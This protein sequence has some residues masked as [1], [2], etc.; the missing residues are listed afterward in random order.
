MDLS[1]IIVTHD[2]E[3]YALDCLRCA[4][5]AA[6]GLQYEIFVIDNAS[7]DQTKVIA[8]QFSKSLTLIENA[9]NQGFAKGI[10]R[11]LKR[12]SG[13]FLLVMNPDIRIQSNSLEPIIDFMRSHPW[14]GICGCR[15]VNKDDSLQPSKGSFPT[16]PS[17]LLRWILPRRLRKYHLWGYEKTGRCDWVTGAFMLMRSSMIQEVGVFDENYFMYYEDVDL[18]LRAKKAGWQTYYSPEVTAF[19]LNPHAL[20]GKEAGIEKQIRKSR[21]YYFKKNGFFLSCCD[22]RRTGDEGERGLRGR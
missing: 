12:G 17:T 5:S 15:L 9:E 14:A 1:I 21:L 8:R 10:N 22:S 13:E 16:V 20:S 6:E 4:T 18:C 19:H 2:S 7:T 11:G 3:K